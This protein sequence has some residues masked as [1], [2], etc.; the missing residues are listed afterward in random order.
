MPP[1]RKSAERTGALG[2]HS[3]IC[4]EPEI[5]LLADSVESCLGKNEES[6]VAMGIALQYIQVLNHH[7]VHLKL[8]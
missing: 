5:R 4:Q 1:G 7:S 8:T 3:C 6:G 2:S